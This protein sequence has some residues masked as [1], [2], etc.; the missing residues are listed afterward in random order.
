MAPLVPGTVADA[1]TEDIID[2]ERSDDEH[3]DAWM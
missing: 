3:G 1:G 2:A